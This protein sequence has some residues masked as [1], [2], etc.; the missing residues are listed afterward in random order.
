MSEEKQEVS[1]LT[2]FEMSLV[3]A[4]ESCEIAR[5]E[6]NHTIQA[7]KLAKGLSDLKKALLAPSVL[8]VIK[9][10]MNTPTGFVTDKDPNKKVK[11]KSTGDWES[12]IPYNDRIVVECVAD[13]M[14]K[15]L[16]IHN[17]EFNIIV[18]RMYP[19]Q[20]GFTRKLAEFKREH[21][22]KA[23]YMPSIPQQKGGA[24]F[25]E[26]LA[27]WHKPNEDRQEETISWNIPA[28]SE[29][30]ALGK[31]KKRANEWLF[32]ELSGNTWTSAEDFHDFS[33]SKNKGDFE[34][35][36]IEEKKFETTKE[37]AVKA[38]AACKTIEEFNQK[39]N[40]LAKANKELSSDNEVAKA[41]HENKKRLGE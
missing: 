19:A 14:S 22:I 39:W 27:W 18:G 41:Y 32:N 15:G 29:D 26:A 40:N 1:T 33:E 11:N 30:A 31:V 3:T 8:S 25:C 13:A 24:Y 34:M 17:N 28:F 9:E 4:A 35:T 38:L 37:D 2:S 21:R 23:G 20:A 36:P 12:P 7:L 10:L 5:K 16:T 6:E